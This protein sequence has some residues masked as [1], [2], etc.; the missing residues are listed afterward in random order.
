[1]KKLLLILLLPFVMFAQQK[2]DPDIE[3]I[4]TNIKTLNQCW[5]NGDLD[6]YMN[7]HWRSE[8]VV[9]MSNH[10]VVSG[11]DKVYDVYKRAYPTVETMGTLTLTVIHLEKLSDTAAFMIG[12]Y[13][14]AAD[15]GNQSGHF[16]LLWK[17]IDGK[18]LIAVDH[19]S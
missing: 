14:V 7:M 18:W 19:S 6:G 1:M 5:N 16:N 15:R 3:Q 13:E 12:K 17:K 8:S 2:A 11:W 9:F 4:L 10:S